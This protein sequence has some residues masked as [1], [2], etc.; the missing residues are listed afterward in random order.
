MPTT[1][2]DKREE[3]LAKFTE[4]IDKMIA[5]Y[6][7]PGAHLR[8]E[9]YKGEVAKTQAL[10]EVDVALTFHDSRVRIVTTP[11]VILNEPPPVSDSSP[12]DTD[13]SPTQE[14]LAP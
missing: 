1:L 5:G 8:G 13:P 6:E 7:T 3:V 12:P 4:A 14:S 2:R 10:L 11:T 9:L